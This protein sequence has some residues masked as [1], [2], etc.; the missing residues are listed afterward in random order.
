MVGTFKK[1]KKCRFDQSHFMGDESEAKKSEMIYHKFQHKSTHTSIPYE[2]LNFIVYF[3]LSSFHSTG[4]YSLIRLLCLSL[5]FFFIHFCFN[6]SAFAVIAKKSLPRSM[7]LVPYV[8][9]CMW[10][11]KSNFIILHVDIQFYQYHLLKRL[12]FLH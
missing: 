2:P 1:K 8:F 11:S 6:Y 4:F 12:F 5:I 3:L 7:K 9:F 10:C